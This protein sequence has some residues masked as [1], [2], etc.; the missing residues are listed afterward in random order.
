MEIREETMH[1]VS[2]LSN[3]YTSLKV[4]YKDLKETAPDAWKYR[5]LYAK[6]QDKLQIAREYIA[7]LKQEVQEQKE[8][9]KR[10]KGEV[11]KIQEVKVIIHG[12]QT[13]IHEGK[14]MGNFVTQTRHL[15]IME[16]M[17]LYEDKYYKLLQET[18]KQTV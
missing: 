5:V 2:A 10:L 4:L 18:Q 6:E 13:V 14:N 7:E 17:K 11:S 3:A 9:I 16:K 15:A 8:D 1:D 12:L